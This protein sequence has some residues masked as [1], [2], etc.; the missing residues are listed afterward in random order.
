MRSV[1]RFGSGIS[2]REE[3]MDFIRL[4]C[5]IGIYT[6]L[7]CFSSVSFCLGYLAGIS[8]AREMTTASKHFPLF[9][10]DWLILFSATLHATL[11]T[12]FLMKR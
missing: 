9:Q 11:S 7:D 2:A 5:W 8:S 3:R 12:T 10:E 4:P 1:I 6:L